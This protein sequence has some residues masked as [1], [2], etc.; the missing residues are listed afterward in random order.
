MAIGPVGNAIY[1]NQQTAS[2]SSEHTAR[3]NRID[4]Q[5]F[6]AGVAVTQEEKEVKEVRP[7]EENHKV[8]EDREHQRQEHDEEQKR[9]PKKENLDKK[10]EENDDGEIHHLDIKV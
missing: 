7:A 5:N 8:D 1:V 9:S 10:K 2:V 6:T 3:N 4:M